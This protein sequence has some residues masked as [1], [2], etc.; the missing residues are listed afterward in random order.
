LQVVVVDP[1]GWGLAAFFEDLPDLLMP[2]VRR[3]EEALEVLE[4]L[5]EEMERRDE[6]GRL[7]PRLVVV[8]D[9]LAD[10]LVSGRG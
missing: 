5:V 3:V 1:K 6:E 9:G 8:L 10:N 2:A 4:C 7:E